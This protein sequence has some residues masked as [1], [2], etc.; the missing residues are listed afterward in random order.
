MWLHSFFLSRIVFCNTQC[1]ENAKDQN[2]ALFDLDAK[3]E[4]EQT[5]LWYK[6]IQSEKLSDNTNSKGILMQFTQGA[7]MK[8]PIIL[9]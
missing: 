9:R 2:V 7:T 8:K 6:P 5:L 1:L 4:I 3:L